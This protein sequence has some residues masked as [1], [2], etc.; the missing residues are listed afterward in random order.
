[1]L[2]LDKRNEFFTVEPSG[3]NVHASLFFI[4][5]AAVASAG[6]VRASW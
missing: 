3:S 6:G 2:I 1:M 5:L 4:E